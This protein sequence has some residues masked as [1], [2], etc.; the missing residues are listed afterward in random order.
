MATPRSGLERLAGGA[1]LAMG[2]V[3]AVVTLGFGVQQTVGLLAHEEH[4]EVEVITAPVRVL[5]V[6][7]EEGSVQVLGTD[8]S[9]V[10]IS[11]VVS[12]GLTETR[13]SQRVTG[14]Q[15]D[16]K[17]R[18]GTL[19]G[20]PWCR[21]ALRIEVPRSL[22]VH[23]RTADGR[24]RVESVTGP[25][26]VRSTD[27]SVQA[28]SLGGTATL[29][30]ENGNVTA[31]GMRNGSIDA[32]S[33][34]GEVRVELAVLAQAV[35]AHSDNGSVEVALPGGETAYRVDADTTSGETRSLVR[36]DPASTRHIVATSANGN[37]TVRYLD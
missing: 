35:T 3:I 1:W 32:S 19:G 10:R 20:S 16:V 25:V 14:D 37:V 34:N 11:A 9:T 21:V 7:S 18:C 4:R 23:V 31:T 8:R 30:S 17:V 22:A 29:R 27:G 36:T 15:L 13:Y 24:V 26:E 33:S 2:S 28:A 5:N 12:D 6:D